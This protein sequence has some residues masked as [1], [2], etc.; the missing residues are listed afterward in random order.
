MRGDG[1]GGSNKVGVCDRSEE[2]R[3][4]NPPRQGETHAYLY[5]LIHADTR[6]SHTHTT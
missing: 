2:E 3:D 5:S 4:G 1:G 6:P